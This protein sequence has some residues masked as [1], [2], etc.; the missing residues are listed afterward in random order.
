MLSR[1]ILLNPTFRQN[2]K[3]IFRAICVAALL[4]IISQSTS[5]QCVPNP[6]GEAAVAL[7]NETSF[8]LTFYIDAVKKADV[9]TG[10]KSADFIVTPGR[11]ILNAEAIIE[12]QSYWVTYSG[13]IPEGFV[14]TLT[15]VDP[16]G[17][18]SSKKFKGEMRRA[19]RRK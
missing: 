16:K 6:T 17:A 13:D 8:L 12:G 7:K 2:L 1:S 11:H 4:F 3:R 5:A 18:K 14:C 10:E 15:I 19:L 9:P